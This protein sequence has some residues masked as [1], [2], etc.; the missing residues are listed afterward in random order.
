MGGSVGTDP[1]WS[2][3]HDREA[4][5]QFGSIEALVPN[6]DV[7]RM[8]NFG[9]N[10]RNRTYNEVMVPT[11]IA[12]DGTGTTIGVE[13]T[14]WFAAQTFDPGTTVKFQPGGTYKI[15]DG[16]VDLAAL[17]DVTIDGNGATLLRDDIIAEPLRHPNVTGY[18]MAAGASNL[19]VRNLH[20]SGV[21]TNDPTAWPTWNGA[22]ELVASSG[23]WYLD[24][25]IGDPQGP[26]E[27]PSFF[28][29]NG[30]AGVYNVA[31]AFEVAFHFDGCT[32]ILVE[33]C[34]LHGMGSDGIYFKGASAGCTVR[35]VEVRRN[36]RQG[37][38]V[39]DGSNFLIDTCDI[40]STRSGIDIEPLGVSET[41]DGVTITASTI[42]AQLNCVAAG[43]TKDVDNVTVTANTFV[44]GNPILASGG[45][46]RAGTRN[47]WTVANNTG[48]QTRSNACITF[49]N[50][51]GFLIDTNTIPGDA[52]PGYAINIEGTGPSSG[53]TITDNTFTGYTTLVNDTPGGSTWSESGNTP[54]SHT[55]L[56]AS[57]PR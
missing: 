47:G 40:I 10:A 44:L 15:M 13:L 22:H 21:V 57:L 25:S 20:V 11:S 12:Y 28:N 24:D 43:S 29:D 14:N 46:G 36:G 3:C 52:T 50:T 5:R 41:V 56:P 19:T 49:Q 8:F 38:A 39:V 34:N 6:G 17:S 45:P 53:I 23:D 1:G 31:L 54:S 35:G 27:G 7:P 16:A 32:N 37:V 4:F 55:S 26:L 48:Q 18:L 51:T 42:K 9:A 33:D 30:D 2:M